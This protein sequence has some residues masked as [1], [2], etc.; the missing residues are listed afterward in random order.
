[1]Q[2]LIGKRM[3]GFGQTEIQRELYHAIDA[4]G[5]LV[6]FEAADVALH[7]VATGAPAVTYCA[8][9]VPGRLECDFVAGCDGFHGVSRPVIPPECRTE[10]HRKYPFGWLGILSET[11]PLPI[12]LY[13]RHQRGFALCSRRDPMLS[14]Y[15][16]QAPLTDGIEDW[17][18]ERFWREL[19]A[20]LPADQASQI[21][22]GASV[23]K[24]LAPVRTFVSEPMRYGRLFLAGDAAHIVPPTGAKGLNLAVS[25]VR[26]LARAL[27]AHYAGDDHLL[28]EYSATA[29]R[30]VWAAVRFTTW[31]TRLLPRFPDDNQLDVRLVEQELEHLA[32]SPIAQAAMAEQYVGLPF[33]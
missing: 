20:R 30:R 15:Y 9:G 27:S 6:V 2:A 26:Y 12:L 31:W 5:T 4:A 23:E 17:P 11:P 10:Y 8:D 33:E 32:S 24:S 13:G 18:D 14:R 25:D 28:E 1:T 7:G 3:M 22:T 19:L 29:L 16:V 21:I